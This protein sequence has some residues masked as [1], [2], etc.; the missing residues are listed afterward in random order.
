CNEEPPERADDV[1]FGLTAAAAALQGPVLKHQSLQLESPLKLPNSLEATWI[2]TP[3]D[4]IDPA[5]VQHFV[6]GH[7]STP[8]ALW[9]YRVSL[10]AS[11]TPSY[12]IFSKSSK[13]FTQAIRSLLPAS[14]ESPENILKEM[15]RM[16]IALTGESE[17]TGRRARGCVGLVGAAKIVMHLLGICEN[18]AG[19]IIPADSFTTLFGAGI[20]ESS[21]VT[22]KRTDL[23]LIRFF[24]KQDENKVFVSAVGIE[25]KY[26]TKDPD[27]AW[28]GN[29]FRQASETIFRLQWLIKNCA[30]VEG[31]PIRAA[32]AIV[33][34]FGLRLQSKV[35]DKTSRVI[36]KKIL[37]ALAEGDLVWRDPVMKGLLVV[38]R[39]KSTSPTEAR[40][41]QD[42]GLYVTLGLDNWPSPTEGQDVK[43]V[44]SQVTD[45]FP[46]I[47]GYSTQENLG[48]ASESMDSEHV[49]QGIVDS[50]SNPSEKSLD[51]EEAVISNQVASEFS[52]LNDEQSQD[53]ATQDDSFVVKKEQRKKPVASSQ[54]GKLTSQQLEERYLKLMDI[55]NEL[56]IDVSEVHGDH[57]AKETPATFKYRV[58]PNISSRKKVMSKDTEDNLHYALCLGRDQVLDIY[59]DE[60]E[61][62]I[63]VPKKLEERY[64][65]DSTALLKL[66]ESKQDVLDVPLG[67]DQDGEVV[68][69]NFSAC[70]HLLIA[71][72]TGS[73]KSKAVETLICNAATLYDAKQLKFVLVDGKG[74][75][76]LNK[77]ASLPHCFY[78]VGRN[79]AE[80]VDRLSQALDEMDRRWDLFRKSEVT[81]IA[82]YNSRHSEPGDWLPWWLVVLDEYADLRSSKET[83]D[84]LED[85]VKRLGTLARAAG[86]HVVVS[87]QKPVVEVVTTTLKENLPARLAFRVSDGGGSRVILDDMGAEKLVGKGDG[88]LKDQDRKRRFQCA[89][90]EDDVLENL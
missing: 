30:G 28:I 83:G 85:L 64:F 76:E 68:S 19:I 59:Q 54:A 65:V 89:M 36:E 26:L 9:D 80:G 61:V 18:H 46:A 52:G 16:G 73:G 70:A 2:H 11:K 4:D 50:G 66:W 23:L 47:Q 74:G 69:V 41:V 84:R 40:S 33:F 79:G 82:Q 63:D 86:I 57:R 87:T 78:G 39:P 27:R 5:L 29:S 7:A 12:F 88:I 1:G 90:V 15:A 45:L 32:L 72:Q 8:H 43:D 60:G 21:S 13:T 31:L 24:W 67:V 17:R 56:D 38:S 10:G 62:V 81:N 34:S 55:F 48:H 20:E 37:K 44:R 58:K 35:Q 22:Q 6:A 71:G 77:F 3:G 49:D 51:N 14:G 42:M 75:V 25:A 53:H